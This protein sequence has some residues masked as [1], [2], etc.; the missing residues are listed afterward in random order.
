MDFLDSPS[1]EL[2]QSSMKRSIYARNKESSDDLWLLWDFIWGEES[3]I[4][5]RSDEFPSILLVLCQL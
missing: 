5:A 1:D 2:R 4:I 3:I